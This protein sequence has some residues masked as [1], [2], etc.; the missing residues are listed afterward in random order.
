[1]IDEPLIDGDGVI[2]YWKKNS[3]GFNALSHVSAGEF[4][5]VIRGVDKGRKVIKGGVHT[6]AA[7][8]AAAKLGIQPI[9]IEALDNGVRRVYFDHK[10]F[11]FSQLKQMKEFYDRTPDYV[12]GGKTLFPESWLAA[13]IVKAAREVVSTAQRRGACY[14]AVVSGVRV[15]VNVRESEVVTLFPHWN[16]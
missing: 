15:Q 8:A 3:D 12:I 11:S 13:D 4:T 9:K 1:M 5:A 6:T 14:L 7:L 2:Y 10:D 16:Q